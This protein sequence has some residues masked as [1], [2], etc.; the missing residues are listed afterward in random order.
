MQYLPTSPRSGVDDADA[1]GR[2]G[3]PRGMLGTGSAAGS[4]ADP[5]ELARQ[6]HEMAAGLAPAKREHDAG[7]AW[8]RLP[9]P[10]KPTIGS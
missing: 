9:H 10:H 7:P 4:R 6:L 5:R 1:G 8:R 2:R 3:A